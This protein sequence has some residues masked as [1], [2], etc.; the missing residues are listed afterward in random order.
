[1]S[2]KA[3]KAR[4][5]AALSGGALVAAA[6]FASAGT[7]QADAAIFH[8]TNTNDSGDGSL[9][10]AIEDANATTDTDTIVFDAGATGSIVLTS[11]QLAITESVS[12]EGPG[13]SV[14]TVDGDDS[15]QVF[16]VYNSSTLISVSLSGLTITGGDSS[17]AGGIISWGETLDLESL[18]ITGNVGDNAGGVQFYG[19]YK[20]PAQATLTIRNSTISGN[21]GKIG[22]AHV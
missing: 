10:K 1:M 9:R 15:S 8:V 12:I 22:R 16:Y 18:V 4:N 7:A 19:A 17:Y 5:L 20:E 14:L 3:K 11:G 6:P 2:N 13:A 21:E